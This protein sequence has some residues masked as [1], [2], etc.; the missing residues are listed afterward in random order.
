MDVVVESVAKEI[1]FTSCI[2]RG[3]G[4]VDVFHEEHGVGEVSLRD[5]R[6]ESVAFCEQDAVAVAGGPGQFELAVGDCRCR[7]SLKRA[8]ANEYVV[9][10][11]TE[12][13]N[14][15]IESILVSWRE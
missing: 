7:V 15:L 4:E 3:A 10:Q 1:E 6:E 13:S 5:E 12:A 8:V 9:K 14:F 11:G 2:G